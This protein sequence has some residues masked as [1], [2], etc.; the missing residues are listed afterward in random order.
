M[1][2]TWKLTP[3]L[4][5]SLGLRYELTPPFYDTLGNL[6]TVYLPHIFNVAPAAPS[7]YPEFMR[8]GNCT[9]PYAGINIT[10]PQITTVCSNGV[11]NKN[12]MQTQWNNFA[13]RVG[14]AYSPSSVWV[15]RLG[16]GWFYNQDIGNAVF[17]MARNIAGRFRI[18]SDVGTPTLF[19]SNALSA[20]NSSTAQVTDPYAFVDA[21]SHRT[22]YTMEYLLNIQR[23]FGNSLVIEAG[24]LGSLSHHLY[25]FQNANEAIPGTTGSALSRTPFPNFGVIQLVADSGNANYNAASIQATKR[26]SQGLSLISSYTYSKSIDNSSGIRVQNYDTLFPQNSDCLAC[27]RGLSSFNVGQR[28]V[29]SVLYDLPVGRGRALD[30]HNVFLNG[31][32]GGWQ[33]GS[34]WTVQSGFPQTITIGGVDRSGTGNGYDRPNAT[35]SS[36]YEANPAPTLWYNSAAF[37]EQPA[38]TFGDVGRNTVVGPGVFALDFDV[39]KEFHMFYSERHILQFRAEAFNVLNHPV[40]SNPNANILSSGFGSITGTTIPMRQMQIALKYTF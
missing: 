8:Q 33:A 9:N 18:N 37:V 20:G 3:K 29:A 6:F 7:T 14:I 38:G 32:V 23:Q 15:V 36:P 26:F 30:V 40:W 35:G 19:W 21:Y 11:L 39:H 25:G 5:L 4:T 13:P 1:D 17:D 22:P 16:Y 34:I 27:E 10:W 24:Y 28:F 31:I 2:D 12:L